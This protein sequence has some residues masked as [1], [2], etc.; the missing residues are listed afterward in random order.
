MAFGEEAEVLRKS[1]TVVVRGF[2]LTSLRAENAA[3]ALS[4]RIEAENS[5]LSVVHIVIPYGVKKN[6]SSLIY[7]GVNTVDAANAL[8]TRGVVI[9]GTWH[10]CEPYA[11][12]AAFKQCYRC[13]SYGYIVKIYRV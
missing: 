8:Y 7:I 2:K 10:S 9:E 4:K 11:N 6:L 3:L 5:D 12:G 13:Y 1:Y